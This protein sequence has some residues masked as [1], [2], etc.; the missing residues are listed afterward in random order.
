MPLPTAVWSLDGS[1]VGFQTGFDAGLEVGG[2]V[3]VR[4]PA[5][6]LLAVQVL[7]LAVDQRDSLRLAVDTDLLGDAASA[8]VERADIHFVMRFVRGEGSVLAAVDGATLSPAPAGGFQEG[9]LDPLRPS[10]L[11]AL[12]AQ[13]LGKSVGLPL[14][15]V[16]G[17]DAE[18]ALKAAGFSR[19]TFMV[20]QSG[21]GK[22][23][24]LGAILERLF[25]HTTLPIYIIDPNSDYVHLG[26]L[27]PREAIARRGKPPISTKGYAALKAGMKAAGEVVVA[28]ADAPHY[29]LAIHLSDLAVPEQ[30]LT[31]D[32]DPLRDRGEYSAFVEAVD[33]LAD[34]AHYGFADV[35]DRLE[36][37]IRFGDEHSVRLLQRMRNLRV[38]D[39]E[40]WARPGEESLVTKL[41]GKRAVV[42]DTGSLSDARARS[43]ISL[44]LLGTL[45]RRSQRSPLLLVVDEAHNVL[46]PDAPSALERAITD[47]GVWIA[48]EGRKYGIHLVVSTQRP[49]KIHRNVISQCDNLVLM[50]MNS[51]ADID[52]LATIF[53]HVPPAMVAEARSFTQGEML[54]AGP[55]AT[56]A[57]RIHCGE[58]WCPEGGA[59][60]PTTWAQPRA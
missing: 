55:I 43:V 33:G 6:D 23:Y 19:H 1:S 38:A 49:Q 11:A 26:R 56:P 8:A 3:G 2:F 32:L 40:V 54:V 18:A 21:S 16:H 15:T 44:A 31:L 10:V 59:D 12:L 27:R 24:S 41:A 37:A 7:E 50:R 14:G 20:G 28:R 39:W 51:V 25:V 34:R 13:G 36:N 9:Q 29:R 42:L 17:T 22:T 35:A 47:Y 60:L 46:A 30:A 52:E 5:G 4:T 58:R 57:V 53:S 45:R 48:G